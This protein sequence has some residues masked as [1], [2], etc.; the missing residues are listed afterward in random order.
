MTERRLAAAIVALAAVGFCREA[1]FH[2]VAE[3]RVE[4]ARP[5][6]DDELRPLKAALPASGE[7]GYV[8]DEPVLTEPGR[9]SEPAKQ[10]FLQMQYALAPLVLR[11]DDARAPIVIASVLDEAHLAPVVQARGLTVVQQVGPRIAVTRPR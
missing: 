4:P 3:P 9:E 1:Y 2:F 10:R 5:R 6:I 8:T 7:V 11:Y